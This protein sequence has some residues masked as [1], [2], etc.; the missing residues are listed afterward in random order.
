MRRTILLTNIGLALS[1]AAKMEIAEAIAALA[2][3]VADSSRGTP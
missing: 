3:T 2:A 1:L